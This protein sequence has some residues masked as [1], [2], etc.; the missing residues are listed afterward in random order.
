M[1]DTA[2]TTAWGNA[3]PLD[4]VVDRILECDPDINAIELS[5]GARPIDQPETVLGPI[6]DAGIELLAHHTAPI[7]DSYH[8]RPDLRCPPHVAAQRCRDLGIIRYTAH[9]PH[10]QH[11]SLDELNDWALNWWTTLAEHGISFAVETM[12]RPRTRDEITK[13]GGYH[14]STPTEVWEFCDMAAAHG[15]DAPLLIDTSH[16]NIG[17]HGGEWTL[18]DIDELLAGAPCDEIHVSINDGR[19]DL[20]S[21]AG[22]F[23]DPALWATPHLD[24]FRWVVDEGRRTSEHWD[25]RPAHIVDA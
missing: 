7:G 3:D 18:G 20:H 15:W 9:P 19:R 11:A 21:P 13:T 22:P 25:T 2:T 1:F 4:V 14:L 5:I 6:A 24:R 10:R 23:D 8:V 16:L 17:L 12:Y